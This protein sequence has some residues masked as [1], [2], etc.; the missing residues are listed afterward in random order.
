MTYGEIMKQKPVPAGAHK[1]MHFYYG[2]GKQ[3]QVF[4]D[5]RKSYIRDENGDW[6]EDPVH[7]GKYPHPSEQDNGVVEDYE[8]LGM[9]Y[10]YVMPNSG[11]L[12]QDC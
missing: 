9:Y 2:H 12:G 3:L 10:E 1:A 7:G 11:W 5:K 6:P 4:R 8:S